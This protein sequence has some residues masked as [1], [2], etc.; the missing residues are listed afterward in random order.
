[1]YLTGKHTRNKGWEGAGGGGVPSSRHV[2][3]VRCE[4]PDV[5][6]EGAAHL[7][8]RGDVNALLGWFLERR[9]VSQ[10]RHQDPV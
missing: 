5:T 4:L 2:P 8:V 3:L 7:Q 9:T 1:M 6:G 10:P